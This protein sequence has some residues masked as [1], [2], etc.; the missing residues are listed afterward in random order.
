MSPPAQQKAL[1][2]ES[3]C[4]QFVV[5]TIEVPKPGAGEVLVRVEATALNPLDWKVQA[6]GLVVEKYPAV[7][8]FDAAGTIVEIGQ[9]VSS[10]AVGDR[11]IVQ[12]WYDPATQSVHG[13]FLQYFVSA[14]K[15]TAKIPASISFDAAATIPSG[16]ASAAIPLYNQ[17]ESAA[18]VRLLPPW[19]EG[20]RG[21]HAGKPFLVLGGASSLGQ[22][23][24][25]FAHL[26]GFSPIVAT[27]SPHNTEF[28]KSLGATHVLDRK[29]PTEALKAEA[30]KIV[31]GLFGC[32]YD[33]VSYTD[34]LAIG[35]ALTAPHGDFVF[36]LPVPEYMN[37]KSDSGKK[38]HFVHGLFMSPVNHAVSES[39]L[40]ALPQLLES[41]DIKPNREELLP[42]GLHGVANGLERL[43]KDQ[44]SGTKLVVRPQDTL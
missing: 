2:L 12:G 19:A 40:A 22:F 24:I 20:G 42:G 35:Y 30:T 32:V 39:L 29:L 15:F 31:G 41:G 3:K 7:L 33:A 25:Q 17:N 10:F 43:R 37:T 8:G 4:G 23:A 1:S 9:D 14:A 16:L 11:V 18:S 38:A 34:T 44:V 6:L 36:V 28:L 26:S 27:A 5:K 13:T 21:K